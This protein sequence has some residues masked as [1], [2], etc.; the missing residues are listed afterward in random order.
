MEKCFFSNKILSFY[1]SYDLSVVLLS[2]YLRY[3]RKKNMIYT[4]FKKKLILFY[5]T[6]IT[7]VYWE[8]TI[9]HTN[10]QQNVAGFGVMLPTVIYYTI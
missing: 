10:D 1:V 9:R 6:F 4:K 7:V 3:F 5:I 8:K 2:F